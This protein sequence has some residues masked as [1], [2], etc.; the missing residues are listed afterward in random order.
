MNV[1]FLGVRQD[2]TEHVH[3]AETEKKGNGSE[4][5]TAILSGGDTGECLMLSAFVPRGSLDV[6][7]QL[8]EAGL[9]PRGIY[10]D[11]PELRDATSGGELSNELM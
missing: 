2:V 9:F 3:S 7:K 5:M 10:A 1:C 11:V 6:L 4:T 8:H